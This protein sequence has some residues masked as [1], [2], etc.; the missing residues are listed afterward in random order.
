[1]DILG[2]IYK[3]PEKPYAANAFQLV[4]LGSVGGYA[5]QPIWAD[6]HNTGIFSFEY[7]RRVA[8]AT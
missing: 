2:N 4:K 6:G 1:M 7:L 5:I 3:N 8:A